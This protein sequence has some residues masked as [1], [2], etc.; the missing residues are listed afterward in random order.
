VKNQSN[1]RGTAANVATASSICDLDVEP[2]KLAAYR[3]SLVSDARLTE[4]GLG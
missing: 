1:I 2:A 4:A 3:N